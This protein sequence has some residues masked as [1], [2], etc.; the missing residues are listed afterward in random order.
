MTHVG[1]SPR[2]FFGPETG[3]LFFRQ[4]FEAGKELLGQLGAALR[5]KLQCFGLKLVD[6]HG[7]DCNAVR[8]WPGPS[9]TDVGLTTAFQ[10]RRLIMAMAVVG[11]KR[12][13][14]AVIAKPRTCCALDVPL[15][16]G[17]SPKCPPML[18]ASAKHIVFAL[19]G[20]SDK[21]PQIR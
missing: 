8:I 5:I 3:V 2:R 14:D 11:C 20:D 12:L 17:F 10:P 18:A 4:I 13:L 16:F 9:P 6:A 7:Q 21:S 1:V 15:K 19:R